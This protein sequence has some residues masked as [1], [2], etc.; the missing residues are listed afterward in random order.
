MFNIMS[1]YQMQMTKD[2]WH[3]IIWNLRMLA[4]ALINFEEKEVG[5]YIN[6]LISFGRVICGLFTGK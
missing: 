1:K 6:F 5:P 3:R 2:H 4:N